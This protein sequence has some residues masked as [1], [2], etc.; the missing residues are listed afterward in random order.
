MLPAPMEALRNRH[1]KARKRSRDHP[2]PMEGGRV[3]D[4]GG[5]MSDKQK[6]THSALRSERGRQAEVRYRADGNNSIAIT[7]ASSRPRRAG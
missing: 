6:N 7:I 5:M 4:A 2:L 3:A 1:R